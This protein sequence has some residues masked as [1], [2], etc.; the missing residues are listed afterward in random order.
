MPTASVSNG[1]GGP[2]SNLRALRFA[3]SAITYCQRSASTASLLL[4][5]A[6]SLLV[7]PSPRDR[8]TARGRNA[9][10]AAE[11]SEAREDAGWNRFKG[12]NGMR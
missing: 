10:K 5:T 9:D 2:M 6:A 7:A 12:S 8:D 1:S 4:A 3:K 11:R